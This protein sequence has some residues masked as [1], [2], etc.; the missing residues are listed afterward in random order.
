MSET[1]QGYLGIDSES[2]KVNLGFQS[3]LNYIR[4]HARS[5]RQKGDYFERLMQKYFTEDPDY[6]DQFSEVY[7]WKEWAQRRTEFDGTDIG[8]DLVAKKHDGTYCAIQCKCYAEDTRVSKPHIDSFISASASE[9]FTSR[10]LVN[11]G[12]ELGENALR[13]IEPLG[14]KFRIIRFRDL[15]NSPFE[16]PDLSL[17]EP[18][19]LTYKQRKFHLKDHQ[20]EAFDDVI[21]GFKDHNRGKLIMA[22]GTG[23]TFTALKIAEHIAGTEGRVLYLVPSISLLSQ[24]MREWSEQ[25]GIDHSYIGI[26]SDTRAGDTTEDSSIQELKIPVTTDPSEI[27]RAL[28]KPDTSKMTVVFCTYQSLPI[29]EESQNNG[30]PQF[31][32]IFCDEAHRTTGVDKPGDKTSHFVLVH[33]AERIRANKRLY[34]TATPR[35]YT[36]N[37][38]KKAADYNAEVFSMDDEDKYGP[39]FHRLPFS[40]AVELGELSDY[41][42]AIFGIS[43][44]EVNAKLAGNTGK[45]GS[46]ININDATRI[47]GCWRALQ[48]PENKEKDDETLRPLKRVIAFTN[49]IDESKA[50]KTYWNQIIEDALEKLPEEEHP[51]NFLCETEHVDGTVHALNRKTRLDWLKNENYDDSQDDSDGKDICRILSNARC[52]SEGIDVPALDAVIFYKPRKSH[53]DVVQAVGRVMRKAPGKQFGYVILPVAIPDDKDPAAALNDNERFSNV[54]SVLNA[55]RSH[56]DR[57]DGQINSIDL[58]KELPDSIVIGGGGNGDP[59]WVGEQLTLMPIEIPVEAILS[60]IVEKCG[61][62]RYWENWAKDV[63]EIFDRLVDRIQ[64][65]LDDPEN[66]TLSEWFGS[67]HDDLKQT[68]NTSITRENAINMMAQHILTSPVFDALFE[69]YDFSSGNPVAIALD[70]LQ[71]D[72][73]EFGLENETRDLQGFYD[74]VRSRVSGVKS[75]EGRQAVLSDLYEQFFKKALKKE[76]DRLGIAYTPIPL[77]DFILH[78]VN[79]VLQEE[80]GKT[81]SDE[82]VHVLD[83][84]TGTGTF[85]VQLLQSGLIQPEDLERKY[86]KEL[87]ANEILLLA[88]YIAS[89]NIEE[90]FRGQR[91]EDKGYEPFEGIILTDTFNLNKNKEEAQQEFDLPEWLPDNNERAENQQELPIQVI[92]G[93]PPWSTGQ[94]SASDNNP[95]IEYPELEGRIRETYAS[96]VD[97]TLKNSLYDTYKMAIRWASDRIQKQGVIAF[98][99]NG[100]WIDGNVDSGVRACLAEEFS[101][102]HVIHLRG[103][104]RTS[105]E[106]RRAE[107]G[108]VFGSGSRAPVAIAILVKNPNATHD[109]CRI[110]YRDIGD[111]LTREERLEALRGAVSINGISN[112][113]AITPN[114][115]YDWIDQRSDAFA[116]FYPIGSQDARAGRADS[117]IFK[118]FSTGYLTGRDAYIYNF[119]RNACAENAEKMVQSYLDALSE[120]EENPELTMDEV[121]SRPNSHIKWDRELKN[122]LKRKKKTEFDCDHIRKVVYRPFIAMNCYADYTFAQVKAQ[123][124]RIF[125][126]SSSENRVICVPNKGS[127]NLFSVLMADTM[128]DRHFIEAAQCFPRWRYLAPENASNTANVCQ[129]FAPILD[130][131][132]NISDTALDAF[133]WHY[134]NKKITKD[135][136]FD[137][138]YGILHAPSYREQFANDLSKMI[139]RIPFAPDFYAF[140]EAGAALASLHL[141]YETCERYPDL[142]VEPVKPSLLWEEKPEHFL[143][144]TRAMRF[145]DKN[146]KTTLIINEHVQLSGIPQEAYKYV[147]NGKTPLDWFIDRYKIT[148]DKKSGITNDPNGWFENPRDLITAIERI[149]YISVESTKIIEGLPTELM[150][151]L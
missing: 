95:N 136:I 27:S 123:Q 111:Y 67:F 24:A 81:I 85:I 49:R 89:V 26:C 118:L 10:I 109:G 86:R 31:D 57:F 127:R 96:R 97:A 60:K 16:W 14:E 113:Q 58:N 91:G 36:E 124:D 72:F 107:G 93:N 53:I 33:D 88:Y 37:A 6:K 47:I 42:V 75:S 52:L 78:S 46:E 32:I 8:V 76:A 13:T 130:R 5:E 146:T 65:L 39:E 61:D 68:I 69:D 135:E 50:L 110:R 131:I 4:E 40:K 28:H 35:L 17:Q 43:E 55:L 129:Y 120:F 34:M 100:S 121:V 114:K 101:S 1:T 45:Y 145:A 115:H 56:D 84:F 12:G 23:K 11:T 104:A 137:Y 119:S 73:A 9:I 102:I 99:T 66:A 82:N 21:N 19:Q 138:V 142:K 71:K 106:R 134:G 147:V 54:W 98:V 140:V 59:D 112:W 64:N 79:D 133:R 38:R 139:P 148:T 143:L 22:C 144:G 70:N 132:D 125:P 94:R 2:T 108:N 151:N 44:H 126:N 150:D 128:P 20:Q 3:V 77:V 103:N 90:A 92:V 116:E 87:H 7:L 18:E 74:S 41:K 15:E 62:K 149:V 63:A 122:N 141:N 29:I 25:R 105:G 83:P 48:N 80:F 30:A 117:V 51:T